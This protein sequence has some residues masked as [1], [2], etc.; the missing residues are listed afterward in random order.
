MYHR[1]RGGGGCLFGLL[2]AL[3]SRNILFCC[4]AAYGTPATGDM[5][6][7]F[8]G[9][10]TPE[11]ADGNS[12]REEEGG[13]SKAPSET[14]QKDPAVA[15]HISKMDSIIRWVSDNRLVVYILRKT[16]RSIDM[17]FRL[18][19]TSCPGKCLLLHP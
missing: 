10:G 8:F 3:A 15:S 9:G 14:P 19:V 17:C 16:E 12:P 11:A 7:R 2:I 1:D 18:A 6:A 5:F 13:R 4:C